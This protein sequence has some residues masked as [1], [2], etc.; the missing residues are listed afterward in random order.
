MLDHI[1]QRRQQLNDNIKSSYVGGQLTTPELEKVATDFFEKGGRGAVIGEIRK[2]GGRDYIKTPTG[3]KFHGKGTGA[4][5]QQH[6]ANSTRHTAGQVIVEEKHE[7][8]DRDFSKVTNEELE[9]EFNNYNDLVSR[10]TALRDPKLAYW[11]GKFEPV[12]K[13]YMKRK[14]ARDSI[15]K[16]LSA[17]Y[18]VATT[19]NNER[20]NAIKNE[21]GPYG[22][23]HKNRLPEFDSPNLNLTE[24]QRK[25]LQNHVVNNGWGGVVIENYGNGDKERTK[26]TLHTKGT[27][28]K[29]NK[30][31]APQ[32]NPEDHYIEN[33]SAKHPHAIDT[34]DPDSQ[35][36]KFKKG[37]IVNVNGKKFTV[38]KHI[39]DGI[40]SLTNIKEAAKNAMSHQDYKRHL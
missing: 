37:D 9:N 31:L 15:D 30:Q 26:I 19:N 12:F 7:E 39:E 33:Y 28:T 22:K 35:E 11:K 40:H 4:K 8:S 29:L 34:L 25:E 36:K 32:V 3:W 23:L 17:T 13:E 6:I 21:I 20:F 14:E 18:K 38:G 27:W 1:K 2:F 24:A 16:H 10:A 5:T